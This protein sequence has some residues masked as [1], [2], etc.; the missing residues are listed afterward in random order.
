[1]IVF[2]ESL[3]NRGF[4]LIELLVVVAII[5]ILGAIVMMSIS[6]SQKSGRDGGRK[7]QVQEILKALE[8]TYSDT[9]A[10]PSVVSGGANFTENALISQFV[11][12]ASNHY[13]KHVPAEPARYYYCVSS[14]GK[15]MMLALDTENDFGPTGS[16]FCHILRGEGTVNCV[17][18]GGVGEHVDADDTCASRF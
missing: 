15:A 17:Y 1:M 5:G 14:N 8:L 3:P 12:T 18:S 7:S 2:R 13:L 11:G 16:N 6:E 10:Y 9:G 4:T